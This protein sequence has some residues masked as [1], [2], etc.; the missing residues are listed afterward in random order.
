VNS[1]LALPTIIRSDLYYVVHRA[2]NTWR[3][4]SWF[5]RGPDGE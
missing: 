1:G 4:D 2:F 3:S 5:W